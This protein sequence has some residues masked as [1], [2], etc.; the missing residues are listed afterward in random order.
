VTTEIFRA[1][2][3][4]STKMVIAVDF[5]FDRHDPNDSSDMTP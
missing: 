4:Y 3:A 1:L 5:K 2:N